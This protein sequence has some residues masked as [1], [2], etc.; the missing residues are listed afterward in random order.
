MSQVNLEVNPQTM[1]ELSVCLQATLS[2]DKL[3]RRKGRVFLICIFRY[4]KIQ[5]MFLL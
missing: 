1:Q 4:L 5:N 3:E 2:A